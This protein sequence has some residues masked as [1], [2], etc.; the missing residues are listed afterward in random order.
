MTTTT[1]ADVLNATFGAIEWFY[2]YVFYALPETL[3][4]LAFSIL[5]GTLGYCAARRTGKKW[6]VARVVIITFTLLW[7]CWRTGAF[8]YMDVTDQVWQAIG[9]VLLVVVLVVRFWMSRLRIWG[10]RVFQY[11]TLWVF[12]TI[13]L[14]FYMVL[15]LDVVAIVHSIVFGVLMVLLILINRALGGTSIR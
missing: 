15:D 2:N 3:R 4:V 8:G 12:Y 5:I 1:I 7:V 9:L 10:H 13:A 11:W 6:L 14:V